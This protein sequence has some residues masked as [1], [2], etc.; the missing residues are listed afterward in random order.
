MER[1]AERAT[2][3]AEAAARERSERRLL[4]GVVAVATMAVAGA[5]MARGGAPRSAG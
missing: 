5:I 2:A 3:A 1:A 4:L